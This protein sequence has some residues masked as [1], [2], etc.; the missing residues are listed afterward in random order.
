LFGPVWQRWARN[1]I[2]ELHRADLP[3]KAIWKI[4]CRADAVDPQ[5][6]EEMRRAGLYLVYMGL[7][8]GTEQGLK[9][10]NKR[11]TVEQNLRA[12]EILK[13]LDLNFEFGFMLFDPSTSFESIAENV[14]FLREVIGDG[15]DALSFCRM[16]PYDGTPIKDELARQG[17]LHGTVTAP[18]YDFLDPRIEALYRAIRGMVE[19]TG[20]V[21]EL[22][23]VSSMLNCARNEVAVAERLFG[24]LQGTAAYRETLRRITQE[25]NAVLLSVV[26]DFAAHHA[27]GAP[28]SWTPDELCRR[29]DVF[30]DTLLR[31]RDAYVLR[32]QEALLAAVERERSAEWDGERMQALAMR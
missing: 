32:N 22:H 11:M 26:A 1:L 2:A 24:G 23:G 7:E 6:F 13:K 4:S 15:S 19:V 20:W 28:A 18:D 16:I 27:G 25:S 3:G 12:V 17:R 30:K 9:T 29:S 21:H 5:L 10:L 31:E 14:T 8:S